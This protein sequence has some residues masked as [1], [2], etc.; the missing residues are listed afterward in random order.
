MFFCYGLR[1]QVKGGTQSGSQVSAPL[2]SVLGF[3]EN[4]QWILKWQSA[5]QF[6]VRKATLSRLYLFSLF[7][8]TSNLHFLGIPTHILLN[9]TGL[10]PPAR[11]DRLELLTITGEVIKT[12]PIRYYPERQPYNLWNI[13]E[14]IPPNEAFF[15][16][17]T[18]YDSQ[19]FV[20]QRVSSVS[21]SSIVPGEWC[22]FSPISRNNV[23]YSLLNA[24]FFTLL[25]FQMHL[26]W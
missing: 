8:H 22:T 6:K 18:G 5:D 24:I 4:P 17:L 26:R 12:L 13:T 21:F 25:F 15:L 14:F 3:P 11:P 2:T 19:G 9:T 20:F 23:V 16:R 1:H 7:I 10:S